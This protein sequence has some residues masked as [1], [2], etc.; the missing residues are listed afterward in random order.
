M[1]AL[2][3]AVTDAPID[4][5]NYLIA[6]TMVVLAQITAH[7]INEYADFEADSSIVNRTSFSGGSGVLTFGS[8]P[9][10]IALQAAIAST[11]L[12][13]AFAG[14]TATFSSSAAFLGVLALA[15]SWAYSMPPLRLLDTGFGEVLTAFT[16]AGLVPAIGATSND[17]MNAELWW[18]I[19]I[20]VPIQFAMLLA[21]E[22]PD[23]ETDRM[24]GKS[25]LAVRIG[26]AKTRRVIIG[27]FAASTA[28]VLVA[29]VAGHVEVSNALSL[30]CGLPFAIAAIAAMRAERHAL[31]TFGA[32][33]TF[34]TASLG[35]L[36]TTV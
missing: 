1:F 11:T 17:A 28:V 16:V 6:Q 10:S 19:A 23:V 12:A 5:S 29:L 27:A 13:L 30:T 8:L 26:T 34:F 35:L 14:L 18:F 25:V 20:L 32:V 3:A 31:M 36:L 22:L 33:A 21:F 2:G 7:Y 4:W 9:R 24:A 15:V